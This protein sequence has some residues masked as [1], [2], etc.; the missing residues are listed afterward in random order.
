MPRLIAF[1][2]ALLLT[3]CG[4]QLRGSYTLPFDTLYIA[5]PETAELRAVLKRNI[6]ASSQTRIVDSAAKAQAVL[7]VT[8]DL[9]MKNVLSLSSTGRVREY[10]LVR[11][12]A[13]RVYDAGNRDV[14]PPGEITIR[15]DITYSDEQVLAKEAEEALLRRDMQNDL[16]QQLLR[17]LAGSQPKPAAAG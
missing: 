17:R 13:Y 12:F 5:L 8:A 11:T 15:R 3:A 7:V 16:V 14:A 9:Q 2:A 1:A 6:E 10:Q 4:F